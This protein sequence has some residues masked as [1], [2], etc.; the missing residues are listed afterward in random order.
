[1]CS[2]LLGGCAAY[3]APSRTLEDAMVGR[4]QADLASLTRAADAFRLS[5]GAFPASL[6][7]LAHPPDGSKPFVEAEL[8]VS[9]WGQPYQIDPD[10]PRNDGRHPDIWAVT[11]TG[12]LIGNWMRKR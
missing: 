3:V 4:A 5:K 7:D 9:P 6:D 12:D 10:G 1:V 8:L 2:L 11:S